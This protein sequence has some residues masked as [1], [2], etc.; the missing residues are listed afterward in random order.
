MSISV[1]FPF[2]FWVSL[3]WE[4]NVLALLGMYMEFKDECI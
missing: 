4:V 1:S 2:E 3:F